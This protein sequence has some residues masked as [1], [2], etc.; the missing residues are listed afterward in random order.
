MDQSYRKTVKCRT[1]NHFGT[2]LLQL[3]KMSFFC[4]AITGTP[5]PISFYLSEENLFCTQIRG[6]WQNSCG[7]TKQ[8]RA[9]EAINVSEGEI[10]HRNTEHAQKEK[11]THQF[12]ERF[13]PSNSKSL[14]NLIQLQKS[15]S[16][17]SLGKWQFHYVYTNAVDLKGNKK[18]KT[19][20]QPFKQL[21]LRFAWKEATLTA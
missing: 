11:K 8:K 19:F 9:A 17:I 6:Q 20:T 3:F 1:V 7:K 15:C 10:K 2:K 4:C 16:S 13:F 14:P 12:Q 21:V 18:N 5:R